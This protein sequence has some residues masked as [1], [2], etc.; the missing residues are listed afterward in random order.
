VLL[1]NGNPRAQR[2]L[3]AV[4]ERLSPHLAEGVAVELRTAERSIV[5]QRV[6]AG[7][8][9]N[10]PWITGTDDAGLPTLRGGGSYLRG[11]GTWLP[12]VPR[13]TAIR[14]A[15]EDAVTTVLHVA[16]PRGKLRD[17]PY[18]FVVAATVAAD[19][20]RVSYRDPTARGDRRIMLEPIPISL[21]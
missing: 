13:E 1:I 20:V 17:K 4:I 2:L 7:E 3:A 11:V 10:G 19:S 15:A 6:A 5:L 16:Y 14:L 18:D 9:R 8:I 12:F 21:F